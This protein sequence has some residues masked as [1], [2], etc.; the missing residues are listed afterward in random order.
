MLSVYSP[1]RSFTDS[2]KSSVGLQE[3][4]EKNVFSISQSNIYNSVTSRESNTR[5]EIPVK[6][7]RPT[8]NISKDSSKYNLS[9]ANRVLRKDVL[10]PFSINTCNLIDKFVKMHHVKLDICKPPK[11][12]IRIVSKCYRILALKLS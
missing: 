1:L 5:T 6:F 3:S 2:A 9:N 7:N 4:S 8:H 10:K 12:I 11:S